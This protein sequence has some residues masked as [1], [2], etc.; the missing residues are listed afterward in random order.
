[1]SI[2]KKY[3]SFIIVIP[4]VVLTVFLFLSG[5][6]QRFVVFF[7][8]AGMKV[9]VSEIVKNFTVLTGVKVDVQFEGSAILVQHIK[10]YGD[11]DLFMSGDKKNMETLINDGFVKENTF[12]AW[13]G[14]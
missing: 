1:M 9:P 2:A 5:K 6:D 12:I 4:L 8:G 10:T 14:A 11:A 7:S 13:G 3:L